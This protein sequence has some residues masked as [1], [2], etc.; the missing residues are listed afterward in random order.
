[1][2]VSCSK[3]L[4]QL[5][6]VGPCGCMPRL[7]RLQQLRIVSRISETY[8]R[9][10][11]QGYTRRPWSLVRSAYAALSWACSRRISPWL[12]TTD[13]TSCPCHIARCTMIHRYSRER[14][15]CWWLDKQMEGKRFAEITPRFSLFYVPRYLI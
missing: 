8:E 4:E 12:L 3:T 15:R 13:P 7:L 14:L 10:N 2:T 5:Y 1:M 6:Y 11:D 9:R